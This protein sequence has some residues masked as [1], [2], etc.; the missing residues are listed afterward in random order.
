MKSGVIM[1][2]QNSEDEKKRRYC[3]MLTERV[4]K[5]LE[6]DSGFTYDE[7]ITMS[8]QAEKKLVEQK[9]GKKLLFPKKSDLRKV[10]RGNPLIIRHKIR[11]MEDINERL[12]RN[13]NKKR[14]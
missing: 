7:L 9:T 6:R 12:Y 4:K 5:C 10:G 1:M 3:E 14:K 13:G 2:G 8:P 11:T